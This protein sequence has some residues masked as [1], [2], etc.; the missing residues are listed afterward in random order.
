MYLY[1]KR[2][3]CCSK[4]NLSIFAQKYRKLF[5]EYK[6]YYLNHELKCGDSTKSEAGYS[7]V[8]LPSLEPQRDYEIVLFSFSWDNMVL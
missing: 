8:L 3:I 1:R 4:I 7:G 2:E 6:K 5:P